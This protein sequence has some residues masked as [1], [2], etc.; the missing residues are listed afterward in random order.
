MLISN[1]GFSKAFPE[2]DPA[3]QA[4]FTSGEHIAFIQEVLNSSPWFS[5]I[6]NQKRQVILSNHHIFDKTQFDNFVNITGKKPG[7]VFSCTHKIKYGFHHRIAPGDI[8][9]RLA[10]RT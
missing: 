6:I 4:D 7:E 10:E 5:A 2:T 1:A 8:L 3:L 9:T